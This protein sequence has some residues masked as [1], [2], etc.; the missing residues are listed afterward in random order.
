[1][2]GS[3]NSILLILLV[4][5]FITACSK[6]HNSEKVQ[7]DLE[8]M[9]LND[10]SFAA[11][12]AG[13]A[14][15]EDVVLPAGTQLAAVVNNDCRSSSQNNS[16]ENMLSHTLKDSQQIQLHKQA[17]HLTLD[18]DTSLND[19]RQKAEDDTCLLEVA[20]TLKL[21]TS[22]ATNDPGFGVQ[23]HLA[24]IEAPAA[25]DI[26]MAPGALAFDAVVAVIDTGVDLNHP[27]LKA[28]L[29]NDGAG[30]AGY[31]FVNR[32]TIPNDD[33]GHGTHVA[34]LMSAVSNNGVGVA[35]VAINRAKVMALKVLDAEGNG[36]DVDIANAIRFAIS[37]KVDVINMSLGGPGRSPTI[38]SAMKEAAAAG[39]TIIMAAG[40][41]ARA[42]GTSYV[43]TPAFYA[44]ETA[45]A[46]AIASIDSVTKR[47][48][49]FS[50]Y[51]P[52]FVELAAPG[53]NGIVSTT[54]DNTYSAFQ[55]TSMASPIVA[56]AAAITVSW[57]K[58][59][60]YAVKPELVKSILLAS[61]DANTN[62][63]NFVSKGQSLNLRKLASLL[64]S[65]FADGSVVPVVTPTPTPSPSPSPVATPAPKP[66][67]SP[68]VTAPSPSP[69][70]EVS[71]S[72]SP[73]KDPKKYRR[74]HRRWWR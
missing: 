43:V 52:S 47:L 13:K 65:N 35:G 27:D 20:H 9:T 17:Y 41:E 14:K 23:R 4:S 63:T 11:L 44:R 32:D 24:S 19:L 62:I 39:V 30:N 37:K 3:F 69:R 5:V 25:Y 71:P 59:H 56:G 40:N 22:A 55:G 66:S 15:D 74:D 6:Q 26:L 50:N 8:H 1:M 45:G 49:S 42:V 51:S 67:P 36:N 73:R 7:I 33:V 72:P 58:T 64:Q 68:V 48:S 31:D 2:K 18:K 60:K 54:P 10:P 34:G 16:D 61:S 29:W 21:S 28:N 57:L 46:L 38:Q 12:N 53:S 70:P